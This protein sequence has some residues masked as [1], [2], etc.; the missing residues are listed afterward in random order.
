VILPGISN[1]VIG[2]EL[3]FLTTKAGWSRRGRRKTS[4]LPHFPKNK[5][6]QCRYPVIAFIG[7]PVTDVP[8]CYSCDGHGVAGAKIKA[9]IIK[10]GMERSAMTGCQG[11]TLMA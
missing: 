11:G 7:E 4:F 10:A 3:L 8:G 5:T 1:C 9:G 2:Y 6:R